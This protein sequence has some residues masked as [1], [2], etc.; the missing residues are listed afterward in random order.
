M[1]DLSPDDPDGRWQQV[2]EQPLS[3]GARQIDRLIGVTLFRI[4]CPLA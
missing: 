3:R 4:N 1:P 2:I